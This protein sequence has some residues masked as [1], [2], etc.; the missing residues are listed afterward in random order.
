M[1]H[2]NIEGAVIV[3]NF[4]DFV[5]GYVFQLALGCCSIF[6]LYLIMIPTLA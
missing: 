5:E 6:T 1:L 4:S 3:I 2:L